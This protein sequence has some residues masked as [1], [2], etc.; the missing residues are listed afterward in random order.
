MN[1]ELFCE[2]Y[3][4]PPNPNIVKMI[5][6]LEAWRRN[7]LTLY[8]NDVINMLIDAELI[9]VYDAEKILNTVQEKALDTTLPTCY[10]S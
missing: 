4:Q 10:I 7:R 5:E 3:Y 6:Q 9:T 1:S 2:D 8:P